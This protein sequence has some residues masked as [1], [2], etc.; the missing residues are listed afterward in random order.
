MSHFRP[1]NIL[2][3]FETEKKT[4]LEFSLYVGFVK[5]KLFQN[6]FPLALFPT[7]QQQLRF[8]PTQIFL[9]LTILQ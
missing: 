6:F 7:G 2:E 5:K 9:I 8:N 1:K 4:I 3:R